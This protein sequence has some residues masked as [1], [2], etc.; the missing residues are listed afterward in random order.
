MIK[1]T[2]LNLF[3]IRY[4]LTCFLM[5]LSALSIFLK[6]FLALKP[7]HNFWIS[8]TYYQ[9]ASPIEA[10]RAVLTSSFM[11]ILV[12]PI[13]HLFQLGSRILKCFGLWAKTCL[14]ISAEYICMDV[15]AYDNY[16]SLVLPRTA[17]YLLTKSS[18]VILIAQPALRILIASSIPAHLS[19]LHTSIES[20]I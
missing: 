10:S 14:N 16:L 8:I 6:S 12:T 4:F 3:L 9:T 18:Y 7:L 15:L 1:T 13:Y 2:F 20:N 19:C 5:S 11:N 17:R